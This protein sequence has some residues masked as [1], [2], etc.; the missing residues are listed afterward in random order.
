MEAEEPSAVG[1]SRLDANLERTLQELFEVVSAL[2]AQP[3]NVPLLR[4]N[5][6]L[7]K[8]AHMEEEAHQA[9]EMLVNVVG[10]PPRA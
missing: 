9:M 7:A 2:E 1:D 10:C 6:E 8:Q 3:N 5:V 4:R